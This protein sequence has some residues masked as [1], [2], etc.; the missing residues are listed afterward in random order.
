LNVTIFWVLIDSKLVP[1][2]VMTDP[3]VP[4]YGSNPVI[5]TVGS[6]VKLKE[7]T[8]DCELTSTEMVPDVATVGT[9]TVNEV[10]EAAVTVAVILLNLTMFSVGTVLKLVP[11]MVTLVPT[12]PWSGEKLVMVGFDVMVKL[13]TDTAVCDPT[14]TE[15]VPDVAAVGTVTVNEVVEAAVTVAIVL[16]N[17]TTLFAAVALKLVPVMVTL[18]PAIPCSGEKLLM[19]GISGTIKSC[20]EVMVWV[21]TVTVSLPVLAPAGTVVVMVVGVVAVMTAVVPLNRTVFLLIS[22]LKFL[23]VRVTVV[24]AIPSVGENE[25]RVGAGSLAS[26]SEHEVR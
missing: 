6:T 17:L 19:V 23:P 11:V 15:I 5:V 16:L 8:T 12:A 7:E 1:E 3:A 26:S 18:V 13:S 2:M 9:V 24:P 4:S 14:C 10:V 21:P 22:V 25:V 20:V